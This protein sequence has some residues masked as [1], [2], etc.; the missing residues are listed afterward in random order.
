MYMYNFL[1]TIFSKFIKLVKKFDHNKNLEEKDKKY[2]L[3]LNYLYKSL[4]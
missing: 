2:Y 4:F 1:K 3:S